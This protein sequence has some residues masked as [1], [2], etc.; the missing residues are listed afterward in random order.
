[1]NNLLK[2]VLAGGLGLAL[3][4][5]GTQ[6]KLE[7][8]QTDYQKCLS[9]SGQKESLIQSQKVRVSSLEEQINLLKNQNGILQ[10]SLKDCATNSNKGSM[11]IEKL[12]GQIKESQDYIKRLQDARSKQDSLNIAISNKLKRSLDN[13]NDQDI[14]IKVQKGVVFI[15]LSDKMLYKSGSYE[16]LPTA[17]TVLEKVA[18]VI[19]DYSDYD[20]MVEGHTDTDPMKPNALIKDNWDLSA[21]RATSVVRMLQTKFAV[22][23]SRMTAGGRS[24]YVPKTDN[25]TPMGKSE[26]RRTEIIVLPKL[27][28]F[29]QL[30]E[31]KR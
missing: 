17:E 28:Q 29:M 19:N 3:T 7:A 14:D 18:R 6:K 20:V 8:L 24:E 10:E 1:M 27:D 25:N 11:N 31:V 30:L 12:I 26:N 4:S 16:I 2:F 15:S 21:L 5:C 23:P 9:D 13:I 22:N